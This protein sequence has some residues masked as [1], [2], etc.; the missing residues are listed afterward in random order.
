MSDL[1]FICG[2]CGSAGQLQK[3]AKKGFELIAYD[4]ML[5]WLALSESIPDMDKHI[6]LRSEAMPL[7]SQK[8]VVNVGFPFSFAL[9]ESF[10]VLFM[11]PQS[12]VNGWWEYPDE[13]D[14]S[15]L[16]KCS[17]ESILVQNEEHAWIQIEVL[18]ILPLG[19]ICDRF[20]AV[21]C[22]KYLEDLRNRATRVDVLEH[23]HWI[24][25][26]WSGQ[27]DL[28]EWALVDKHSDGSEHMVLYCEWGFHYNN[29]YCGNMMISC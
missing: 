26:S 14:A 13:I 4:G 12:Q 21:Q 2:T 7:Q 27:G 10:W 1:S 16:V 15:A 18:D 29:V 28:G 11:P 5:S 23:G 19:E 17:F 9:G 3:T 22:D 24:E 25:Y 20:P 8:R 6:W